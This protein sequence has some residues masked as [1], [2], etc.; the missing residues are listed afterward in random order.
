MQS[1][2]NLTRKRITFFLLSGVS[3]PQI[4]MQ[5]NY[6]VVANLSWDGE[7]WIRVAMLDDK[8][9]VFADSFETS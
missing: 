1:N 5:C 8:G 7:D 3:D 9:E 4:C 6:S 2:S